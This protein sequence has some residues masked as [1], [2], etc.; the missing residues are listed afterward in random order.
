MDWLFDERTSCW[1]VQTSIQIKDYIDLVETAHQTRGAIAGQ[2]D[3]LTTTTAK[4]IRTRMIADLK[5]GAVLPPVVIG[6]VI[7]KDL[8]EQLPLDDALSIRE[9]LTDH[10]RESLSIIDGMQRTAAIVE[11]ANESPEI[12]G[13]ELRVEFWLATSVRAMIYRMLVLNTGQVPWTISRQLSVVFDP[14]LKE[15]Q[16]LS[17]SM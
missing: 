4:R 12:G 3:V 8:F 9:V 7:G 6:A 2:R 16:A 11:A 5:M 17:A 1:S 14:L 15:I 13:R 10:D